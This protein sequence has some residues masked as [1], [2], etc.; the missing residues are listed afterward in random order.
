MAILVVPLLTPSTAQLDEYC[1]QQAERHEV[2]TY[3]SP[4]AI[5]Q[6]DHVTCLNSAPPISSL[7]HCTGGHLLPWDTLSSTRSHF[8][9]SL[10]GLRDRASA[11]P[12][13]LPCR[14][15]VF[16]TGCLGLSVARLTKLRPASLFA[17]R[18]PTAACWGRTWPGDFYHHS[19]NIFLVFEVCWATG[20]I[21]LSGDLSPPEAP[22]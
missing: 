19:S 6:L 7:Q 20:Q 4:L 18:F 15:S 16:T 21:T 14:C 13:R 12:Y 8:L 22:S 5:A 3:S 11:F 17:A 9:Q 1:H 2:R 10:Q